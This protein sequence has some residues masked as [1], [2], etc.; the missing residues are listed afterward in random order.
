MT[1]FITRR[2][3]QT[4]AVIVILSYVCY[5]LMSL[6]PG[7][8][9]DMMVASNPK[10]TAE[11]VQRLKALYGLDQ[12]VYKRFGN[13][14]GSISQGDLGYSRTYRVPVQELMGPRLWNT[15]ILSIASLTLSLLIAIPLGVISALKPGSRTDYVVNLFSF[16]G[17]SIPSFWLAIV[18]IIIFA[19]KIPLL[20][21]GGTQTIGGEPLGFWADLADRSVYLVLPVLSLSIQQIGRFSRF[22]RSAMLEAMRNDFIRTAR[23]KGLS[24]SRV[25]WKHAFRNALIPLITIL[26]LSFSGLFSGA[27]L[28]ET[29]FAYQG[30][31]KLVYDSIIQNDY[32]V[33]MISFVISVSMVLLM[34]L[35]ADIAYGFADPRISYQ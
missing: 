33:A 34:N 4:L 29:V 19:V 31:G 7:D 22:T 35:V 6:M 17:I 5:Y 30:V 14:V 9:V 13:W 11:D 23:A 25:I 15:F 3:L 20:P 1:T 21:A 12:P 28:T 24:R 16:A 18:L 2:I 8:P 26:A 10:I 27:I 32:N